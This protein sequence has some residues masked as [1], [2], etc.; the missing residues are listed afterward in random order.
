MVGRRD[1]WPLEMK[2]TTWYQV[3]SEGTWYQVGR[4]SIVKMGR[5]KLAAR[6]DRPGADCDV[7]PV[8]YEYVC[9]HSCIPGGSCRVVNEKHL[10]RRHTKSFINLVIYYCYIGGCRELQGDR[11]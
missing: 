7:L 8:R 10:F 2:M 1:D 11:I 4:S 5:I 9:T 3:P 6:E